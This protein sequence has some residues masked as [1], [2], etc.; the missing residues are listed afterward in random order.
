MMFRNNG[1]ARVAMRIRPSTSRAHIR[2]K[3]WTLGVNLK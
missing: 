3:K 2:T 1:G